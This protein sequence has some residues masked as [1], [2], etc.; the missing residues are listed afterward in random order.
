MEL[1]ESFLIS[2]GWKNWNA[3]GKSF[4]QTFHMNCE[5]L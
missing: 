1:S 3:S 5:L 4:F 2:A